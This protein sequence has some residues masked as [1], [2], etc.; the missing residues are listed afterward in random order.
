MAKVSPALATELAMDSY[1]K[2][3]DVVDENT[4]KIQSIVE[5][6]VKTYS[7]DID[8][9]ID[10]IHE[11]LH[12][13]TLGPQELDR[14][15][16]QIPLC[17][18]YLSSGLNYLDTMKDVSKAVR[19]VAFNEA[20]AK[21]TGTISD[22]DATAEQAVEQETLAA[23]TFDKANKLLSSKRDVAMELLASLKKVTSRMIA[24]YELTRFSGNA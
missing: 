8:C 18:F 15:E 2:I 6:I 16:V 23:I 4:S 22:K 21:A 11:K 10:E 3:V 1:N 9:L 5:E 13:G 7:K 17:L 14:Y 20:R 12:E 24:E 19:Q